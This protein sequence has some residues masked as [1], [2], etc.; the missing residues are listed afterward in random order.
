MKPER[1][2]TNI[3]QD[4]TMPKTKLKP[5]ARVRSSRMVGRRFTVLD[6]LGN[7]LVRMSEGPGK[8]GRVLAL[9]T[10]LSDAH[11]IARILE[12]RHDE[13]PSGSKPK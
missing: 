13:P 7:W 2:K 4:M 1:M 6:A 9:C 10:R 12:A 3:T 5:M 8:P 11:Y